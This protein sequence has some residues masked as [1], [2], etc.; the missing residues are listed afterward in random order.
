MGSYPRF[1]VP[2]AGYLSPSRLIVW[3][4]F[5]FQNAYAHLLYAQQ[6]SFIGSVLTTEEGAT[7][8]G[9]FA[10]LSSV[11]STIAGTV[12]ARSVDRIGLRGLM[13]LAGLSLVVTAV[14]ADAAYDVSERVREKPR[15]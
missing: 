12:V 6:W 3:A 7:Y 1:R 5:V 2:I 11:S 10:G 15:G 8:F 9:T 14:L 4:S 13:G